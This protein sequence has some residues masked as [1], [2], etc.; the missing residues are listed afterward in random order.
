MT[1]LLET[2]SFVKTLGVGDVQ[3]DEDMTVIP[4]VGD[5]LGNIAP[6]EALRFTQTTN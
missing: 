1:S 4:L 6:P 2:L 5:G 3:S